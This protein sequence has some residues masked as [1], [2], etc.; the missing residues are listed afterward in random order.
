MDSTVATVWQT[1][2]QGA[3]PE[4]RNALLRVLEPKLAQDLQSSSIAFGDLLEECPPAESELSQIHY[5]W[6]APFLRTLPENEIKLFLS[7]LTPEQTKGLKRSL[8]L[9]NHLPTPSMLGHL[10]LRR[11]LFTAIA[12]EEL[13]PIPCLPA[14]PLNGL[15]KLSPEEL[16]SLIHLLSMH[17]LSIEIRHIIETTKLK[18]IHSILTKAQRN[19]LKTLL[20][21]KEPV[22]FKKMGL[23][24]WKGDLEGLKAMLHQ[25]GVNRLAK[26]LYDHHP[27][28]LWY[29]AHRLDSESGESLK[30]LCTPL[31]HPRAAALLTEQVLELIGAM[32]TNNPSESP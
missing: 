5:S 32:N 19:F 18:E 21:K 14:D 8:L 12:S 6:F 22:A 23:Q 26:A 16:L 7:T 25:R 20:H 2:L 10:F 17:D 1:L 15:L 28:L 24:S 3:P 30:N 4:E 29:V 9:T 31:D 11:S 13:T 27:H